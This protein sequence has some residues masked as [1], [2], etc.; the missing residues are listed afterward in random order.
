MCEREKIKEQDQNFNMEE[1]IIFIMIRLKIEGEEKKTMLNRIGLIHFSIQAIQIP[2]T[3]TK[4]SV[5]NKSQF[6][7]SEFCTN[8]IFPIKIPIFYFF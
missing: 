2:H 4:F 5:R 1:V 6:L 3:C 8:F 7:H